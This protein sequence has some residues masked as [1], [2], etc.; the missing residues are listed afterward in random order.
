MGSETHLEVHENPRAFFSSSSPILLEPLAHGSG[1]W[2]LP[3]DDCI[4]GKATKTE[5]RRRRGRVANTELSRRRRECEENRARVQIFLNLRST[6]VFY[7]KPSD[8]KVNIGF[9]E[10]T[11]VNLSYINISF[12]KNRC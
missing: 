9:L 2:S 8:V 10:E 4:T 1:N 12:W 5:L 6:S 11:D 7:F 3:R